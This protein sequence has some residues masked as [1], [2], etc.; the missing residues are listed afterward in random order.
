MDFKNGSPGVSEVEI[1]L[2]LDECSPV[3]SNSEDDLDTDLE[4]D[5]SVGD[6]DLSVGDLD[7]S[8]GDPEQS[9]YSNESSNAELVSTDEAFC[10]KSFF[11]IFPFFTFICLKILEKS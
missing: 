6:L 8:V 7:L 2:Q 4:C 9:L 3:V 5:L 1:V 11:Q 10:F